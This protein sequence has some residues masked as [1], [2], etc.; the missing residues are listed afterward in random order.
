MLI[1]ISL[2]PAHFAINPDIDT[3]ILGKSLTNLETSIIN[4]DHENLPIETKDALKNIETEASIL[5][6]ALEGDTMTLYGNLE[7]RKDI[8][9]IQHEAKTIG[10]YSPKILSLIE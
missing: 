8:L 3:K 9:A 6:S 4:L 1:I 10:E 7:L 5:L 2:L